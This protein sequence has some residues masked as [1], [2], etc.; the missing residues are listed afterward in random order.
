MRYTLTL[1]SLSR[2]IRRNA[3]Q[4]IATLSAASSARTTHEKSD[5][6]RLYEAYPLQKSNETLNGSGQAIAGS[7]GRQP[8][9]GSYDIDDSI[10]TDAT[11]FRVSR[12]SK[13][14]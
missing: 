5:L 8:M 9:V 3:L 6:E 10:I 1:C 7:L 11:A 2:S 14:F 4:K 12:S 13:Y